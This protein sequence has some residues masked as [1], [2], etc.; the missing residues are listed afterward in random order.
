MWK[1]W[2]VCEPLLND[3]SEYTRRNECELKTCGINKTLIIL[4]F[5]PTH[6][7][8]ISLAI[9]QWRDK[10]HVQTLSKTWR[11][12]TF[13]EYNYMWWDISS[14]VWLRDSIP[15]STVK[16]MGVCNQEK[17]ECDSEKSKLSWFSCL[18]HELMWPLCSNDRWIHKID[19]PMI[20]ASLRL[21]LCCE[22][23]II[24]C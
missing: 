23:W 17:Q 8:N 6:Y 12:L 16:I 15:T 5:V 9:K 14:L 7:C 18:I 10:K 11:N 2:L 3:F 19:Y 13:G 22:D 24:T 21:N 1:K 20:P 4:K